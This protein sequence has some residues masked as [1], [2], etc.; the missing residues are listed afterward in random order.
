MMLQVENLSKHFGGVKAV[1]NVSFSLAEGDLSSIIGP[2]GAGKSTLFNAL[3]GYLTKDAGRVIFRG[4]DISAL[5]PHEICRKRIGRSFQVINLFKRMTVFEN[6]QTAIL[7][8]RPGALSFVRPA[9]SMVR[10]ETED[11]LENVGLTEKESVLASDLSHGGQRQL[12][13]AIALA[14]KPALVFLDEPC[15]GLAVEETKSMVKLIQRLAKEQGLTVLLVE[16]KMDVVF[17]ISQKIRVLYE[18]RL[19]F[20][21]IPEEVKKSE[22]VLRV[23]LGETDE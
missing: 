16:H 7:A 11:I 15:A 5:P 8:G 23:Y 22:E 2:N 19:I 18:G 21:G 13:L 4:E 6:I 17:S 14:N 9:K 12:E 3:T 20:E 10:K 1:D